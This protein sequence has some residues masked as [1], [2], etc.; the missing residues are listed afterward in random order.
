MEQPVERTPRQLQIDPDYAAA[1]RNLLTNLPEQLF[2]A[3]FVS[4]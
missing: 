4:P 1:Y 2:D 3:H